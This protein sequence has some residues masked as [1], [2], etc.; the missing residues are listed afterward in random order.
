MTGPA[1]RVSGGPSPASAVDPFARAISGVAVIALGL[2]AGA[3]L[4]EGA[5]MVPY[6]RA[7]APAAFLQWYAENAARLLAFFGPLEAASAVATLA[8]AVLYRARRRPGGNLLVLAGVLA[9]GV[10]VPFPLYFQ[11]V[12]ASFAAGT[13]PLEQVGGELARWAAWHWLRTAIGMGAFA[14]A[15]V[16]VGRTAS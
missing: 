14:A 3:M 11:D 10:L 1:L 8:A 6:W 12:N 4:A 7:L 16:A 5:V 13:I 15:V 2:S 9:V